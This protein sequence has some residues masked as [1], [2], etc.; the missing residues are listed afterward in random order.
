[1]S[2][3]RNNYSP[4]PVPR[5][6]QLLNE[7]VNKLLIDDLMDG[8]GQLKQQA[9]ATS[10][11]PTPRKPRKQRSQQMNSTMNTSIE[12][13]F[14]ECENNCSMSLSRSRAAR[15]RSTAAN[16]S[17]SSSTLKRPSAPPPPLPD[18]CHTPPASA[19]ISNKITFNLAP[20]STL[21]SIDSS[22]TNLIKLN[23]NRKRQTKQKLSSSL[24]YKQ[25]R[26]IDTYKP[27]SVVVDFDSRTTS[28]TTTATTRAYKPLIDN[29]HQQVITSTPA[30][31]AKHTKSYYI[32]FERINNVSNS[33]SLSS[34]SVNATP[35]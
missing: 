28:T 29:H 1:M 9:F 35:A 4:I 3:Q 26:A 23:N 27:A 10:T 7:S 31:T 13:M 22:T 18:I 8:D 16:R 24:K 34:I 21:E 33:P 5:K 32:G 2:H 30:A 15:C 19:G 17:H 12:M 14:S 25:I 11:M 20:D 6:F